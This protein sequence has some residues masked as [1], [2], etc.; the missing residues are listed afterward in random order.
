M[1]RRIQIKLV[2]VADVELKLGQE[3]DATLTIREGEI[4]TAEIEKGLVI[5]ACIS[6]DPNKPTGL[7]AVLAT[8]LR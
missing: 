7:A 2:A 1:E 6:L 3:I 4:F 8:K 5:Q